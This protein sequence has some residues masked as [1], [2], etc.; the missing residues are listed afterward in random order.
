LRSRKKSADEREIGPIPPIRDPA[1]R[2]AC[3]AD[4]LLALKTYFPATFA[5]PWSSQHREVVATMQRVFRDGGLFA[6]GMPRGS[7][8]TSIAIC[9]AI[10]ALCYGWR[11]FIAIIGATQ[12][13]AS[14]ILD[15]IKSELEE[16]DL[17]LADFPEICFPIRALEYTPSRARGQ[18]SQGLHTGMKWDG[19]KRII[20]PTV[21]DSR[22]SIVH[23]LSLLGNVRGLFHKTKDGETLRPTA[24]IGDDLQTDASAQNVEQVNRR[25]RILN[26]GILGMAGPGQ[27]VAGVV[28]ITVQLQGDLADRLLNQTLNPLWQG[29]RFRLV[30]RWPDAAD[31]W[32]EYA[33]KRETDLARG[34]VDLR[35]ATKFY[36]SNRDAMDAG[37]IV[38]WAERFEPGE[39]S[40]I[41]SAYN[42]KLGKPLTFDAEY[43]NDPAGSVTTEG[44]I[45]APDSD[46]IIQRVNGYK[47]GEIPLGASHILAGFD[48][49]QDALFFLVLAMADDFTGWIVDYGSWPEQPMT[50]WTLRQIQKT[51]SQRTG[52]PGLEASLFAAMG[53][54]VGPML[55]KTYR[56]DDGALMR[57]DAALIDA[58]WGQ[59]TATVYSY[60]RQSRHAS[61]LPFHGRGITAKQQPLAARKRRAGERA[62]AEWFMPKTKGT[63]TPR[64]VIA[65]TNAVKTIIAERW[66]V[67][68]GGPGAWSLFSAPPAFHRMA[69]DQWAAE[70][71]VETSGRGRTLLE[72][73]LRPGRDNHLLDCLTMATTA[74]L[75]RGCSVAG[76]SATQAATRPAR[77]KP[78]SLADLRAEAAKRKRDAGD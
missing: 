48:V 1:R 35:S 68:L 51:I 61:L 21:G 34:H 6:L 29:R 60:C 26:G 27:R 49:Q 66:R 70:Y 73:I 9:C 23:A 28:T 46:Q 4:L 33:E 40:A 58:N 56:R 76:T 3:E 57:I 41:Q 75:M 54:L 43:Q 32:A 24:F 19:R 39:I 10:L 12:S 72:W 2:A 63:K 25:E 77:A 22:G 8:K 11:R 14:G 16:N 69:A 47:R 42:L 17:L 18:T 55:E 64:H 45:A 13:A 52:V 59:S 15:A 50:Y 7:G 71:P 74:G 5:L 36:K 30:E 65:D 20:L 37:A 67:P 44:V 78:R 53:E 38:P 62:G 31:L